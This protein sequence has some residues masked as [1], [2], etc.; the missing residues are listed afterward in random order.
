MKESMN[1]P[2]PLVTPAPQKAPQQYLQQPSPVVLQN[3]IPHQGVMNTPQEV[4]PTPLQIG[5]YQNPGPI[6]PRNPTD[7]NILLISE[8][9]ILL[10]TH[11]F[12]YGVPTESNP[13]IS[14]ATPATSGQPLMI[15]CPNIEPTI[16]IPR[17]PL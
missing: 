3:P 1:V 4:H 7:R 11:S 9:E 10:Q 6:H 15:P 8:E 2:H 12:H 17:I 16:R 14:E 5:K 13:T